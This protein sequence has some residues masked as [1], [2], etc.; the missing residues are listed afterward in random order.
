MANSPSYW[1][2]DSGEGKQTGEIV[3]VN[4]TGDFSVRM[5]M[6]LA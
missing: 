5:A 6:S 4:L 2:L 3:S 1:S